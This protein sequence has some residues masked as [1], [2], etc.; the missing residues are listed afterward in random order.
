MEHSNDRAFDDY[1]DALLA[2][3]SLTP[4]EFARRADITDSRVVHDLERLARFANQE[5]VDNH[6]ANAKHKETGDESHESSFA[7]YEIL[8]VLG[9]GG[10]GVVHLARQKSLDRFVALKRLRPEV[11]HSPRARER[12]R[13]EARAAARL[14][15][16]N[17][18]GI[19]SVGEIDETPFLVMEFVPG[20]TL[21][22]HLSDG[23]LTPST[24][25]RHGREI[26]EAL[27]C[28]HD[29]GIVHRDVK[30][31]NILID[32]DGR[33]RL[34]DF[35]LAKDL[36]RELHTLTQNFVGSPRFAAPEQI[37][38]R[39][40]QIGPCSDIYGLGATLYESFA[41]KPLHDCATMEELCHSILNRDPVPLLRIAPGT[42]RDVSPRGH[43]GPF[44]ETGRSLLH[45]LGT[46]GRSHARRGLPTRARQATSPAR[47]GLAPAPAEPDLCECDPCGP[48]DH[49]L[50]VPHV[51]IPP[52]GR[53]GTTTRLGTRASH[54]CASSPAIV[55]FRPHAVRIA[56]VATDQAAPG[57]AGNLPRTRGHRRGHATLTVDRTRAGK[58]DKQPFSRRPARSIVP[59]NWIHSRNTLQSSK[60]NSTTNAGSTTEATAVNRSRAT[61]AVRPERRRAARNGTIAS[62]IAAL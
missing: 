29:N 23:K 7:D 11:T 14:R 25:L 60:R 24:I 58:G 5:H 28:A 26:A 49:R 15:H 2:G 27:A 46:R 20:T 59:R 42:P 61:I 21:A 56:T 3:E 1:L 57:D 38:G 12:F 16:P 19:H 8:R 37:A 35:G 54:P 10:M 44:Q 31:A 51:E 9:E 45:G 33:A 53:S 34:S 13:R 18:V 41:K 22:A 40:D 48:D 6:G 47:E 36:A 4:Q 50:R 17:I 52:S 39:T 30:P 62:Q 32:Q 55:Q 43:E